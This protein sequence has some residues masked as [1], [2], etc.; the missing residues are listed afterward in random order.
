[1]SSER[2]IILN[3]VKELLIKNVPY[4][5]LIVLHTSFAKL[6][7]SRQFNKW[8]ALYFVDVLYK[9]G[10][11]IALPSFTFDFCKK[12]FFSTYQ[13]KS[14]TGI[15]ADWVLE[16]LSNS[17]RTRDP[18]YSF[19]VLGPL[20][21]QILNCSS[22]TVW[23]NNS[24]FELYEKLNA[25]ILMLGCSW[26]N[27][28]QIHRYEEINKVPYRI[29]KTFRGQ[30]QFDFEKEVSVSSKMFV[31][32]YEK[33]AHND[34]NNLKTKFE[35]LT[36]FNKI[37]V[38]RGTARSI[39]VKDLAKSVNYALKEN[40]FALLR[41][42]FE[43]IKNLENISKSES[44]KTIKIALLGHSNQENLRESFEKKLVEFVPDRKF[45]VY[46]NNF[47]Q[48]N[49]E[50]ID[51][52]S[53]LNKDTK[54]VR[55]FTSRIEDIGDINNKRELKELIFI[56]TENIKKI[57]QRQ[58]GW[59]FIF[60]FLSYSNVFNYD[61]SSKDIEFINECNTQ[62]KN[63]L[64]NLE[65]IIYIDINNLAVI[66]GIKLFDE[67]LW[68]LGRFPFSREFSSFLSLQCASMISSLLGKS[69]RL[70]ILDLDNTIWGGVLGEDGFSNLSVD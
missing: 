46:C 61:N 26:D 66:S 55:I 23:G 25:V 33:G 36:S 69:I 35:S 24:T 52:E 53:N 20:S 70:I 67:R 54:F 45:D 18:I 41:N 11:T 9:E 48:I 2:D 27:C 50:I 17:K 34:L 30:A 28:T 29:Y 68:Y 49:N 1:M 5:K 57:H 21:K 63:Q 43:T 31:R 65:Q 6:A 47:G 40:P 44:Q 8:D 62:M 56:Y 38:L 16:N 32:D 3:K 58:G 51:D 15:L 12:N 10:W 14:E 19:V 7:P 37:E 13:S 4:S 42:Q 60:K 59:T 64:N 22:D 39:L